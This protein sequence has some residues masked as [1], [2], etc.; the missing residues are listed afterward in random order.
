MG[1]TYDP[2]LTTARDRVR[3]LLHDTDPN[4]AAMRDTE[5]DY[6]LS[7]EPNEMLAAARLGDIIMAEG[8]GLA[9]INIDGISI[10]T[11]SGAKAYG[12]YIAS[13]RV[14]GVEATMGSVS[15]IFGVLG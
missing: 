6:M 3:F 11:A 9:S 1:A 8:R 12:D 15:K 4:D 14:R 2:R 5:I 10:N 7:V 13:L